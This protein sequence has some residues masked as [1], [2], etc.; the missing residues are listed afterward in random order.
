[1]YNVSQIGSRAMF[2]KE[3]VIS[4]CRRKGGDEEVG[5]GNESLG[6]SARNLHGLSSNAVDT[7]GDDF[8]VRGKDTSVDEHPDTHEDSTDKHGIS[9]SPLVHPIENSELAMS[10]KASRP[11]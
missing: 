1:M 7:T 3:C 10:F 6:G 9:A 5:T 11:F 2:K 8:T 4:Y